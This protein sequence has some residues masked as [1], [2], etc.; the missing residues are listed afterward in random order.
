[1]WYVYTQWHDMCEL[2]DVVCIVNFV[3]CIIHF[4]DQDIT[5]YGKAFEG[6]NSRG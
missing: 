3:M 6:E 2:W 1:M 5:V 4:A